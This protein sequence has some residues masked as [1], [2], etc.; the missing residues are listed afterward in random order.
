MSLSRR[1]WLSTALAVPISS[2]APQAPLAPGARAWREQFPAL[3]Q[4]INGRPLAYLDNAATTQRP[5]AVT[6][7]LARYDERD[8][9]NPSRDLHT[10]A[11]RSAVALDA[12]RARVAR[13][14][15]AP[16]T[17][18]VIFTRGTTEGVNLIAATWG[19]ARV[20]AGDD[21]VVTLAEHA[22]NLF[23]WQRLARQAGARLIVV[24]LHAD[25]RL[26]LSEMEKAISPRTRLVA[27]AHVSNVLGIVY[28][29]GEICA[30]ARRRGAAV[31]VDAAQSAPHVR[32]DVQAL[33]CDFLACSSHKMLGP[34]GVGV[35][36][37]RGD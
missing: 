35:L 1:E 5:R 26:N 22:S 20:H 6:E 36:W 27:V 21:I 2:L 28:P 3:N 23:P 7:A 30:L 12:A 19:A 4:E 32:L 10:L 37:I 14:I 29:V 8:N 24:G 31:M 9:A 16:T 11:K 33:G 18:Q 13:F 15:N 34:M 25:G 17:D